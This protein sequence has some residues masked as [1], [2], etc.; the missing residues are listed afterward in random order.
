MR[1]KHTLFFIILA[2]F[3]CLGQLKYAIKKQPAIFHIPG[4]SSVPNVIS[5]LKD[6]RG[7]IW[8][9][10]QNG[11]Y[12]YNGYD[13]KHYKYDPNQPHKIAGN[14][15]GGI[16]EDDKGNIW[17]GV[18]GVGLQKFDP[19]AE[20]FTLFPA[21]PNDPDKLPDNKIEQVWY[22]KGHI[23]VQTQVGGR[24]Y[25]IANNRF[26]KYNI[27]FNN[28]ITDKKGNFWGLTYKSIVKY[29]AVKDTFIRQLP[30]LPNQ[31][32][33]Y[34][35]PLIADDEHIYYVSQEQKFMDYNIPKNTLTN[36]D[37][38]YI[39]TPL[40]SIAFAEENKVLLF[41]KDRIEEFDPITKKFTTIVAG[42]HI[43]D[44]WANSFVSKVIPVKN[45]HFLIIA[46]KIYQYNHGKRLIDKYSL[47]R[48]DEKYSPLM[49]AFIVLPDNT[50]DLGK[51]VNINLDKEKVENLSI[52]YPKLKKF[53]DA[54][55]F[56]REYTMQTVDKEGNQWIAYLNRKD[57]W[58]LELY[59]YY[60]KQDK[61]DLLSKIDSAGPRTGTILG[62]TKDDQNVWLAC[63]GALVKYDINSKQISLI[64][65]AKDST[66]L[67]SN[68]LRCVFVDN[69]GDLWVGTQNGLN[70]QKKGTN[71][72][73]HYFSNPKNKNSLTFNSISNIHQDKNGTIW[74]GTFSGLNAFNK[75]TGQFK[76][77]FATDLISSIEIQEDDQTL[78]VAHSNSLSHLNPATDKIE[79][80]SINDGVGENEFNENASTT[81]SD[82]S[83]LF[84]SD[85]YLNR[86]YPQLAKPDT[87][88]NFIYLTDIKL[89]NEPLEVNGADGIL[90]QSISYSKT[91][92]F[93]HNQNIIT[94]QYAALDYTDT[95]HRQFA[96][97][98][99]GL[100]DKWQYVGQQR[101]V[102]FSNL[103]PGT[104]TFHVK[105]ANRDGI[106]HE[107]EYPLSIIILP[108]WWQTWWAYLIYAFA[109][110]WA[111]T[112]YIRYRSRKLKEE[113]T[114]L[115]EKVQQ[116]TLELEHSL[117]ELKDTQTQL[118]QRE[119]M[120]SLGELTAGIA[121]EIQ[122]PLNFVN[123]F[124]ELSIELAQELKDEIKKSEKDWDLIEDLTDDLSQNQ[125]KINHHG[126]RASNIVK[127]MLEH[128]RTSTGVKE[129]TDINALIREYLP[130]SYH[131][132]RAKDKA[133][134]ADFKMELDDA[135]GKINIIPQ[136][137]GRVLLNLFN[138]AFYAVN[139]RTQLSKGFKP[140][141]SSAEY[142][143]SVVVTTFKKDNSIE[144]KVIDNGNG[145]PEHLKSKI[146]QPFFTTKPTGEGT[147][148][149]L[150]LSYDIV[151][152]GH[153]GMLEV[154]SN[155]AIGSEF[156]I[157]LPV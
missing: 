155:E 136:D 78:W 154:E 14:W 44:K 28:F 37:S 18:F 135:I 131:G 49:N 67:S 27:G 21:D 143:P 69:D 6:S 41:R 144:I 118:I 148:L 138:N 15:I 121:H 76:W 124:S 106:W 77:Y 125:E 26:K 110:L 31:L 39:T 17:F 152:K 99:E 56:M 156:K 142:T 122:N 70:Y 96:Y 22:Y 87:G 128:S 57:E 147:G 146:F 90:K 40:L 114:L 71:H 59:K 43:K 84:A 157:I 141:E 89:Y 54:N 29:D 133:F 33:H 34:F 109:F 60:P 102:T 10:T 97:M 24:S 32:P 25:D 117:T 81:L 83:L 80:Y 42:E 73:V 38:L 132:M 1:L 151:V 4:L 92:T 66:G 7:F 111:L 88:R 150:S 145:I 47:L 2:V 137:M 36:C 100:I 101:E 120:A 123:N 134:N 108:P 62:F 91:L 16:T 23:W 113:N 48:G 107:M 103:S 82:G 13:L 45:N 93:K 140:L 58:T 72:F 8:L 116:R 9:G 139:Q 63:W 20:T 11:L 53:A 30:F 94:L 105:S 61:L 35:Y 74:I 19:V 50:F 46:D 104:Y 5:S 3:N 95:E 75:K 79:N 55:S 86:I 64:A 65:A 119:K 52:Q 149:G 112:A 130:L 115:E 153:G 12:K 127:G 85:G 51:F 129:P 126:K 98:L 68:G